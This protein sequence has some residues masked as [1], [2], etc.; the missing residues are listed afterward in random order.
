M[1]PEFDM[2]FDIESLSTTTGTN[3]SPES[4]QPDAGMG[5]GCDPHSHHPHA[6]LGFSIADL[7][8]GHGT[9]DGGLWDLSGFG[10][11][12]KMDLPPVPIAPSLQTEMPSQSTQP[13]HLQQQ[14]P[15][16]DLSLLENEDQC[17]P[18]DVCQVHDPRSKIGFI[19]KA[20]ADMYRGFA[21]RREAPFMHP[22]LWS[23]QIPKTI[24]TAFSAAT[25]YAAQTPQTKGWTLKV[26]LD[27][28]REVHRD[29]ERATTH[30][31]RLARVQ[32][33]FL[34][35]T[36]RIFDGDLGMR[37]AAEREMTVFLA[38]VKDLIVVKNELEEGLPAS[39]HML[40]DKPPKSWEV[41]SAA[42][43]N[44][45]DALGTHILTLLPFS[46]ELDHDRMHKADHHGVLCHNVSP[47]RPQVRRT[48]V[49][50][51]R[52]ACKPGA[53]EYG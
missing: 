50:L 43:K 9:G 41:S 49:F 10:D 1:P 37:A 52:S 12:G 31:D 11:S 2:S 34:L 15:I 14:Q 8:T 40:R 6:D 21:Q 19:V 23:S 44:D 48:F 18:A 29:G 46:L 51:S 38:W 28:V 24:L 30:A 13:Q 32:A 3:T 22:R 25:A 36:M 35:N 45:H 42:L 53:N 27:A 39:A 26:L 4:L 17:F 20:I 5:L 7:M 16:R 47:L 33:L